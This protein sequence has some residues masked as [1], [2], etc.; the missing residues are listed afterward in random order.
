MRIT[1]KK[2]KKQCTKKFSKYSRSYRTF[3]VLLAKD[4]EAVVLET[5]GVTPEFWNMVKELQSEVN[6]LRVVKGTK[7]AEN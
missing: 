6:N 2:D 3:E 7:V 1:E 5:I 4:N